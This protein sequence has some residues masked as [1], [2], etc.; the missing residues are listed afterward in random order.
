MILKLSFC[1]LRFEKLISFCLIATLV[2]VIAPLLLLFSLRFGIISN[3]ENNLKAN[4]ANLEIKML[5]GYQLD[6]SFFNELENNPH[7]DFVVPLTR[8]LSVTANIMFNK[9]AQRNLDAVPTKKGDPIVRLSGIT[10]ELG[11]KDA[12]LSQTLVED[13]GIKVGDTFK[14]VVSRITNSQS[15]NAVVDFTL[16]GV[17]KKEYAPHKTVMVNFNTLVF[18]EDYR[19]GYEPPIFSDGSYLNEDRQTF[20]KARMYVKTINDIEPISKLLRNKNYSISDKLSL[21]ESLKSITR[22]LDFIFTTIASVSV[23]GGVL[24]T[25]GLIFTNISR[26]E[27]SFALLSLTGISKSKILCMVIAQNFILS[28]FAYIASLALFYSGM[29]A[30]NYYF[31]D[32]LGANTLV[33]TL[34]LTHILLGYVFTVSVCVLL[35]VILWRVKLYNLQ[36]ANCLRQL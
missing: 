32:L 22:V 27:K 13:L 35:S 10:K 8:S 20:S 3:L 4:P 31:K 12:Y 21:V 2:S 25:M 33:S 15:D 26:L 6:K 9:K 16:K 29:F 17:I 19:D 28:T 34:T 11:P 14:F 7:M 24:A 23:I 1:S 36:I 18:M 5:A 30:F